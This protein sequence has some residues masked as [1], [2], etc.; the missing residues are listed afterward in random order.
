MRDFDIFINDGISD[1]ERLYISQFGV[2]RAKELIYEN[3]V[4]ERR[5]R[6]EMN[7]IREI[8]KMRKENPEGFKMLEQYIQGM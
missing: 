4:N 5:N 2:E 1:L 7:M 6:F 3:N 8:I